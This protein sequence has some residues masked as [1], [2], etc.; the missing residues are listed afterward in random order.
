MILCSSLRKSSKSSPS[1]GSHTK[2]TSMLSVTPCNASLILSDMVTGMLRAYR[3]RGKK[4]ISD[5]IKSTSCYHACICVA[6]N[7]SKAYCSSYVN[8]MTA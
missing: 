2:T 5:L 7:V 6:Q 8:N 3:K 4:R 1:N